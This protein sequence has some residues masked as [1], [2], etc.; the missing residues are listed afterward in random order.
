MDYSYVPL[1]SS[2]DIHNRC[3]GGRI[4]CVK[5]SI[6]LQ[7]HRPECSILSTALPVLVFTGYMRL[8]MRFLN[9]G[10]PPF[11]RICGDACHTSSVSLSCVQQHK[12]CHISNPGILSVFVASPHYAF[13]SGECNSVCIFLP[14]YQLLGRLQSRYKL[15]P[16]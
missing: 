15:H 12:H 6:L 2:I 9:M 1:H 7:C 10:P 13:R 3:C 14:D 4:W 5:A 11:C 16:G 8:C